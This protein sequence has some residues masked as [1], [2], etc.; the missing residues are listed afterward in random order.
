[1]PRTIHMASKTSELGVSALCFATPRAIDMKRATWTLI[2]K[3]VSC[4]K[5][6]RKLND[7]A[8]AADE[9]KTNA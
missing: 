4:A 6:K 3:A 9:D 8:R 5:C 7:A 1:M 2:E